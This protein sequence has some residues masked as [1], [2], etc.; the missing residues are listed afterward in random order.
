M[1]K[2]HDVR[3][4]LLDRLDQMSAGDPFPPERDLAQELG[5]SRMTL[6][7]AIDELV[8]R[9]AVRRRHGAGVFALG[10]KL[11]QPLL[12]SSF[13][14]D[15]RARGLRPG[16]RTL[17]FEVL[18]AGARF[19]RRLN[20]DPSAEITRVTRLRLADDEPI[21]VEE[22][23]VP[24]HLMPDLHA[25][26]LEDR[27]FYDLLRERLGIS[28]R[29][30]VQTIEPTVLDSDEAKDLNVPLHSPALMFE[31]TSWGPEGQP[32]EFVRSL[33][34]GDRYKIR[35]ELSVPA[36]TVEEIS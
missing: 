24:R 34:R 18:P 28:V 21:A 1:T 19:G 29:R 8:A 6:R 10:P 25:A 3:N 30:S 26:D 23:N 4:Q 31:R 32:I 16:A 13:S 36:N 2:Y 9:G 12:A 20:I 11:D 15:M 35:T 7:R 17:A 22:L 33:Y 27:S 14:E 5:V